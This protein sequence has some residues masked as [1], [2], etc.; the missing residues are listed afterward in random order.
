MYKGWAICQ[1]RPKIA[2]RIPRNAFGDRT[3]TIFIQ[4]PPHCDRWFRCSSRMLPQ[5]PRAVPAASINT[6]PG[7]SS[8][9][10]PSAQAAAVFTARLL[11]RRISAPPSCGVSGQRRSD[12]PVCQS[13]PNPVYVRRV[14]AVQKSGLVQKNAGKIE[15]AASSWEPAAAA[16]FLCGSI[17]L[18]RPAPGAWRGTPPLSAPK[19]PDPGPFS[20]W[21]RRP[22]L[23]PH[24][25]SSWTL[26]WTPYRPVPQS[27]RLPRHG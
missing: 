19:Y 14:E 16:V 2:L 13:M 9:A 5:K 27:V 18:W 4:I 24:S 26:N 25:W 12:F 7:K 6:L 1:R 22:H 15:A 8:T 20:V 23:P 3:T 17:K 10:A 21:S 11:G